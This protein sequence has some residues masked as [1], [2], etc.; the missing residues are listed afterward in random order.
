MYSM[1]DMGI[2]MIDNSKWGIIAGIPTKSDIYN[3][4]AAW[5]ASAYVQGKNNVDGINNAIKDAK[6]K[7]YNYVKM[8]MGEYAICYPFS[9]ELE[10]GIT[11]DLNNGTL[12][13]LFDSE[14]YSPYFDLA[15]K[16][17]GTEPYQMAGSAIKLHSV[18]NAH[19]KNGTIIGEREERSF[20][21]INGGLLDHKEN[22]VEFTTGISIDKGTKDCSIEQC[23]IRGFMGDNIAVG[24]APK[25][26]EMLQFNGVFYKG[27]LKK[28]L[29]GSM[30]QEFQEENKFRTEYIQTKGLQ[31]I[32]LRCG[33]GYDRIPDIRKQKMTMFF[34]DK[35]KNS[36]E[37]NDK[38]YYL[39]NVLVPPQT[40]YLRI[41]IED[42]FDRNNLQSFNINVMLSGPQVRNV[43]ISNCEIRDGH[44]GGIYGSCDNLIIENNTIFN[45]G[46]RTVNGKTVPV[47]PDTTR[48]QINC[49]DS[50]GQNIIIKNNY[51][52]TGFNSILLGV[53]NG[54]VS[55]NTIWNIN[56]IVL[57]NNE[58]MNIH[59]NIMLD[60][61]NIIQ[62]MGSSKNIYRRINFNNNRVTNCS[63]YKF[64]K[65]SKTVL[66]FNNNSFINCNIGVNE[67]EVSSNI[68][69]ES[70]VSID[71][72]D[73]YNNLISQ[74]TFIIDFDN[75][76]NSNK[77]VDSICSVEKESLFDSCSFKNS[78]I[79]DGS[80]V[81]DI[82]MNNCELDYGSKIIVKDD[83][84]FKVTGYRFFNNCTFNINAALFKI[85]IQDPANKARFQFNN[86][87]FKLRDENVKA[88]NDSI[89][90]GNS[91]A[92]KAV[93]YVSIKNSKF[94]G[95]NEN[96]NMKLGD[97]VFDLNSVIIEDTE[98]IN[99]NIQTLDGKITYK[100]SGINSKI[101]KPAYI[102]PNYLEIT[103]EERLIT[104]N[105]KITLVTNI[106][107]SDSNNKKL[108]WS[109]TNNQIASV[110]SNGIVTA[111]SVQGQCIIQ[112]E[113]Y[114]KKI[115]K[116]VINVQLPVLPEKISL[117]PI[118]TVIKINSTNLMK[119]VYYPSNTS[120]IYKE[121]IWSSSNE[122]I[123]TV[124]INGNIKGI[125][126]G[127]VTITAKTK[128]NQTIIGTSTIFVTD[129]TVVNATGINLSSAIGNIQVGGVG[130]VIATIIPTNA[131]FKNITWVLEDSNIVSI[132]K[133]D[134]T[135]CTFRGK[136]VGSTK[137]K[138]IT[139]DG[140]YESI[141]IVNVVSA[142]EV[143]P[144][145]QSG[146][147]MNLNS[148]DGSGVNTIWYDRSSNKN[149]GELVNFTMDNIT[150]GWINGGLKLVSG[151]RV[152]CIN[153]IKVKTI[154]ICGIFD[155]K[156]NPSGEPNFF[157]ALPDSLGNTAMSI[158]INDRYN[159]F[160]NIKNVY[161]YINFP[162]YGDSEGLLLGAV[163][164]F[165]AEIKDGYENFASGIQFGFG[166]AGMSSKHTFYSIRI[167]D[168]VLT[169]AERIHNLNYDKNR[170]G[171]K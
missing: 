61:Y 166:P 110:D 23:S 82:Y 164:Y 27:S 137:I 39:M 45:N 2:Y 42:E 101:G 59:D 47:F 97:E 66:A 11:L 128:I 93:G 158:R 60:V 144:P 74:G 134:N 35:N 154:E 81:S 140:R 86:C 102:K 44:R 122:S 62:L 146:L 90:I 1:S 85:N 132:D 57:Y 150:N 96:K 145:I 123:A 30:G 156:D 170:L 25:D 58:S 152:K 20:I 130:N 107:P 157:I 136:R 105:E 75:K 78:Q 26:S 22:A 41:L 91:S 147:V 167:Y 40:V 149:N 112:A 8:Q 28:S 67:S 50:Y 31:I 48:Y 118:T 114:N 87:I 159:R 17:Y 24:S 34:Y 94:I 162:A 120:T 46:M 125:K 109:S 88:N 155:E 160:I 76:L 161:R 121:V 13:V 143:N 104:T 71:K 37:Y 7:G 16:P 29:D 84:N 70:T 99:V 103:D 138:A 18:K 133:S 10:S 51:I 142:Q 127:T 14:V 115:A 68:F 43:K 139:E 153:P 131:T 72:V 95:T 117:S 113:T 148:I 52:H 64:S 83:I 9:I 73:F 100:N 36:I 151:A 19:V 119:V 165:A 124:D 111:K 116:C 69:V 53:L 169:E 54:D 80:L 32:T 163:F 5:S 3:G 92:M 89:F 168:R 55:G 126:E 171:I 15:I 12:K 79:V 106:Y 65:S 63:L 21:D 108:I 33:V 98:F 56:G 77:I 129:K 49:E 4:R 135:G 38:V 6:L 141:I